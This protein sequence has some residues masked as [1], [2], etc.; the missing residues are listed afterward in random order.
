MA[1]SARLD[2]DPGRDAMYLL[3]AVTPSGGVAIDGGAGFEERSRLH[4]RALLAVVLLSIVVS[5]ALVGGFPAGRSTEPPPSGHALASKDALSSL[6]LAAQGVASAA[7]GA[8]IAGYRVG[9]A[10]AGLQAENPA[11]RL[12]LR[13]GGDGVQIRS[14]A[15]EVSLSLAGIGYGGS[16]RPAGA[17]TPAANEN[18]VLYQRAG[19]TEWFA[20]GPLGLEQGFTLARAPGRSAGPLTLSMKLSG[21]MSATLTGGGQAVVLSHLHGASLRYTGLIATDAR[22]QRLDAW[23]ELRAGRLVLRVDTRD[24][25]YPVRIDPL[26]QRARGASPA[27][28]TKGEE[29]GEF[30]TSV[31]LA[32]NGDTALVGAPWGDKYHGQAWVFTRSGSTW[33]QQAELNGTGTGPGIEFGATVALSADGNTALIGHGTQETERFEGEAWV[34]TRSGSTWTQQATI[35]SPEPDRAFSTNFGT[36]VDLSGDGNT[37]LIAMPIEGGASWVF[38]RSGSTWSQQHRFGGVGYRAGGALSFDGN[39]VLFSAIPVTE[40]KTTT[41]SAAV[42]TRDEEGV[43]T[44]QSGTLE[45]SGSEGIEYGDSFGPVEALSGDGNTA[46]V[47][48]SNSGGRGAVWVFTRSEGVWTQQGEKLTGGAPF[49]FGESGVALSSDGNAALIGGGGGDEWLFTRAEGLWTQE[50]EMQHVLGGEDVG[51]GQ[52]QALSSEGGET[53]LVGRREANKL[54]G[55]AP[56]FA[57]TGPTWTQ[58]A[59]LTGRGAPEVKKLAPKKGPASGGTSV[60]ITGLGFIGATTVDFGSTGAHFKVNSPQSISAESPPGVAGSV[61][62]TVTTPNGTSALN[63]GDLFTYTSPKVKK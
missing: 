4:R 55:V 59:E 37:A 25:R 42:F 27:G 48:G 60:T 45:P 57:R 17:A 3:R 32:A 23:L 22:E 30:G 38:T 12:R 39:T 9:V 10:R 36:N 40:D 54:T 6:P 46:I 14:G 13:F 31:A 56:V 43:W 41:G 15:D 29:A 50:G 61:A 52:S 21:N 44:R 51:S 62:V 26:V 34:F 1:T 7:V 20:N 19:V 63:S 24:A 11:Q 5:A 33:T 8:D 35:P 49:G 16:L 28:R 18:R 2:A 53:V 47:R 58:Q